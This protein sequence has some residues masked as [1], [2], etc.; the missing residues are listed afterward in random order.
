MKYEI[1]KYFLY[2]WYEIFGDKLKPHISYA[3]TTKHT[4]TTYVYFLYENMKSGILLHTGY[5][6]Q[7]WNTFAHRARN[8]NSRNN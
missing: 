7:I 6:I 3:L 8:P 1:W 5:K 4:T 2:T